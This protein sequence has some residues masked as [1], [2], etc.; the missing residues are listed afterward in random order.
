MTIPDI[1]FVVNVVNQF[2]NSFFVWILIYKDIHG[3]ELVYE[4]KCHTYWAGY[5]SDQRSTYVIAILLEDIFFLEKQELL[6]D[7]I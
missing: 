6:L 7:P 3:K 4:Y 5:P 1:F 2:L